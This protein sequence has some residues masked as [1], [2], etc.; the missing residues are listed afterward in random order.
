MSYLS[1][2]ALAVYVNHCLL[3]PIQH[4]QESPVW[5]AVKKETSF[6]ANSSIVI[7]HNWTARLWNSS[8]VFQFNYEAAWLWGGPALLCAG[9]LCFGEISAPA[10][11]MQSVLY[12]WWKGKVDSLSQSGADLYREKSLPSPWLSILMQMR[13]PNPPSLIG[14]KSTV[15]IGRNGA[16]LFSW[17]R[18]TAV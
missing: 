17:W 1:V 8:V 11:E 5:G 13:T 10:R 16:P 14:P 7:Q 6:C 4:Q 15:L 12:L 2:P 18:G 3:V 9:L